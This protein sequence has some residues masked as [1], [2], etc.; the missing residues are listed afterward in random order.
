[1]RAD[2]RTGWIRG[3]VGRRPHRSTKGR[4]RPVRRTSSR[5][6][7]HARLP[8]SGHHLNPAGCRRARPAATAAGAARETADHRRRTQR[9]TP[10]GRCRSRL[11]RRGPRRVRRRPQRPRRDDRRVL[12]GSCRLSGRT[13][14]VTS[15]AGCPS[16]ARWI[17]CAGDSAPTDRRRGHTRAGACRA[18][19]RRLV[20][21]ELSVDGTEEAVQTLHDLRRRHRVD[22]DRAFEDQYRRRPSRP[23]W[24]SVTPP[25]WASRLG[26]RTPSDDR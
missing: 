26:A 10:H 8:G 12:G 20:R 4:A 1:M 16:T 14:I 7:H 17:S 6:D 25:A 9:R 18:G 2:R 24:S 15:G 3:A 21:L 11:R 22:P 13:A 5:G 23:S 19:R